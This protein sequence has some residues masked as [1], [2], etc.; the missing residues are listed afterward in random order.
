MI[1]ESNAINV[2]AKG[3]T[4]KRTS[5]GYDIAGIEQR[6]TARRFRTTKVTGSLPNPELARWRKRVGESRAQ[7]VME[8][9]RLRGTAFH[10][11]IEA[12]LMAREIPKK[13]RRRWKDAG[14]KI[15]KMTKH[16]IAWLQE[17][18]WRPLEVEMIMWSDS[19]P[20]AGTCDLWAINSDGRTAL[21]DWKTS[22]NIYETHALQLVIYR[23]LER[24]LVGREGDPD[25]V[26]GAT[27]D[28]IEWQGEIFVDE[29]IVVQV[30]ETGVKPYTVAEEAIEP[31]RRFAGVGFQALHWAENRAE[32]PIWRTDR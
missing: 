28:G 12:R 1:P 14:W 6:H 30:D 8:E 17:N 9:A 24:A 15:G 26:K 23:G 3:V 2:L 22:R 4:V 27:G 32:F 11:S 16:V 18:D 31:L 20:V 19:I 10:E 21:I 5:A 13:T 29:L 25:T 7:E